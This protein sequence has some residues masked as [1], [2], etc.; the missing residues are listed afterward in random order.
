MNK[1]DIQRL[2]NELKQTDTRLQ[3]FEKNNIFSKKELKEKETITKK[4][5]KLL[6]QMSNYGCDIYMN[7]S[8]GAFTVEDY[9]INEKIKL[10]KFKK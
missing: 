7:Y 3:I 8:Q 9:K 10:L 6:N 2:G 1:Y 4:T 5:L